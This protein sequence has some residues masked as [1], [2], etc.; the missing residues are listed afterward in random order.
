[1]SPLVDDASEAMVSKLRVDGHG[2]VLG[3]APVPV[4]LGFSLGPAADV[5]RYL[6]ALVM[7]RYLNSPN[8]LDSD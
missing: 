8:V 7:P 3:G 5:S 6:F 2:D 1:M 4:G